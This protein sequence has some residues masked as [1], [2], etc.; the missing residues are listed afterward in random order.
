MMAEHTSE[1]GVNSISE[2]A[3][4][5]TVPSGSTRDWRLFNVVL[6]G[7]SFLFLFTVFRTCAA[8]Q[9]SRLAAALSVC[10]IYCLVLFYLEILLHCSINC[11]YMCRQ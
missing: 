7:V 4:R 11:E 8:V 10:Y 5:S 2:N 6:L 3:E 1:L 9:V